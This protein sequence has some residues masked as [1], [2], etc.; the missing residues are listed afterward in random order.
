MLRLSKSVAIFL[1]A[2]LITL[3][4][5]SAAPVERPV[6]GAVEATDVEKA[7]F[8]SLY[9]MYKPLYDQYYAELASKSLV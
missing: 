7:N 9:A 4:H 8:N 5:V 1:V 3:I 6:N 2:F